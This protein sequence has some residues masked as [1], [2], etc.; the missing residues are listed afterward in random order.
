MSNK[1]LTRLTLSTIH[2]NMR[3]SNSLRDNFFPENQ[4]IIVGFGTSNRQLVFVWSLFRD[5]S[6]FRRNTG[7]IFI[8]R[9]NHQV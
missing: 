3:L 9:W 8:L 7:R 5:N 2:I 6:P 1:A 4:R